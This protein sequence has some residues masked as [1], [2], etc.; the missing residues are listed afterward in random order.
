MAC[1]AWMVNASKKTKRGSRIKDLA[2]HIRVDTVAEVVEFHI[3]EEELREIKT[4]GRN[5]PVSMG[6]EVA[7]KSKLKVALLV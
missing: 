1:R 5:T 7:M 2:H 6:D 3:K 4:P